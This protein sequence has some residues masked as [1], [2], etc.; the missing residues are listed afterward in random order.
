MKLQKTLVSIIVTNYNGEKYL[1]KCFDSLLKQNYKKIELIFA[2]DC[3]TD[4]SVSV[5]RKLYPQVKISINKKNSG[6]SVNSNNGAKLAKGEYLLFYNNDTIAFPDF[7]E[8]MVKIAL[9]DK[10]IGVVCPTQLPYLSK[11]DKKMTEDQK[12]YAGSDIFGYVCM[13]RKSGTIFYPDASI[14]IRK[15]IFKKIGG[16][17]GNF[18]LYGEDMDLCHRVHLSG[19]KIVPA[20]NAF[21]RHDS[22]CAQKEDGKISTS[23]KRRAYVER[24]V[25]NKMIKYYKFSTLLWFFPLFSFFFF[26]EALFFLLIK[27]NYKM[28]LKVYLGAIYWNFLNIKST[29]LKR[30]SIQKIRILSDKEMLR[31]MYKKYSKLEAIK[32]LGIPKIK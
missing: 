5:V 11:D 20:K 13:A 27:G 9:S 21:F 7:I 1:K 8:E 26:C 30:K 16:F 24:Q 6:L 23:I 22:F 10:N 18:F 19:Y 31:L 28:F 12:D 29:L 2:D 14:F 4:K 15:D 3:S 25:I 17:D 32:L